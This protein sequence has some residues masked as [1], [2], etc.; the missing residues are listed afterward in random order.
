MAKIKTRSGLGYPGQTGFSNMLGVEIR[1]RSSRALGFR[2]DRRGRNLCVCLQG[3]T[4]SFHLNL[5]DPM[6]KIAKEQWIFISNIEIGDVGNNNTMFRMEQ[7]GL[8]LGN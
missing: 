6:P 3:F 4:R 5:K 8:P 7:S 2:V 1:D